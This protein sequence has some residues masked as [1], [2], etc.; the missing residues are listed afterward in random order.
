MSL[1]SE[2][3]SSQEKH[4]HSLQDLSVKEEEVVVLKVELSAL[5]EKYK[6]TVDEVGFLQG[7]GLRENEW[8]VCNLLWASS[9]Y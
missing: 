5:Q 6:A 7:F 3:A 4:R 9:I 1:Q 8:F 2:L